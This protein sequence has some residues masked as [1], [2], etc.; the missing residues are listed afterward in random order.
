[1]QPL[2]RGTVGQLLQNQNRP[3]RMLSCMLNF[4]F[5]H[6]LHLI[7]CNMVGFKSRLPPPPLFFHCVD[8]NQ[9]E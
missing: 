6:A 3:N 5:A 1:M 8:K 9:V 7:F 4:S 2:G